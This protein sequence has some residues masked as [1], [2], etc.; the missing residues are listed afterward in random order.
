M[1]KHY[2]FFISLALLVGLSSC[3]SLRIEKRHY[4]KGWYVDFG[5][6]K[7]TDASVTEVPEEA[8][9]S[10]PQNSATST[11]ESPHAVNADAPEIQQPVAIRAEASAPVNTNENPVSVNEESIQSTPQSNNEN[12]NKNDALA[13]ADSDVELILLVIL[14]IILPPIAVYLVQGLSAMF[15]ITLICWLL[16]GFFFFGPFGYAYVGGLGLV[17]VVLALLVVFGVL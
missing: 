17:A 8:V 15:W 16:G 1:K 9:E 2:L 13:G 3:S 4:N 11:V 10:V 6:D 5:T 7:K 12:V 14:A